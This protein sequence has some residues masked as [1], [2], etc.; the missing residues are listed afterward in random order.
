MCKDDTGS[1][2]EQNDGF[3]SINNYYELDNGMSIDSIERRALFEKVV[4]DRKKK[5]LNKRLINLNSE[6]LGD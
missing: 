2:C 4:T 1:L 5:I 3:I 6:C